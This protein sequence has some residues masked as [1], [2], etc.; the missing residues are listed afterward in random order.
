MNNTDK[1]SETMNALFNLIDQVSD[2]IDAEQAEITR[3]AEMLAILKRNNE[4][5]SYHWND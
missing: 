4:L 5:H 2:A 1:H 3:E